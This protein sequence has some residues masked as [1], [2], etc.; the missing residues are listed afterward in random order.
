MKTRTT[1]VGVTAGAALLVAAV[2]G[3]STLRAGDAVPLKATVVMTDSTFLPGIPPVMG[4]VLSSGE[5]TSSHLG[6]L[7]TTGTMTLTWVGP[8]IWAQGSA[9]TVAANGDKLYNTISGW[10]TAP[11]QLAGTFVI[12]GGTGRFQGATGSGTVNSWMDADG[13]QTAVYVGLIDYKKN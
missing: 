7:T 3:A 8:A 10:S 11:G 9:V 5:G 12:T 6:K 2:L 13:V 1:V 4:T